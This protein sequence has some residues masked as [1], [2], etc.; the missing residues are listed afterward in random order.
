[1]TTTTEQTI[2]ALRTRL[3]QIQAE[4]EADLRAA[5]IDPN[6]VDAHHPRNEEWT[7][8]NEQL[9]ALEDDTPTP[10]PAERIRPGVALQRVNVYDPHTGQYTG[11]QILYRGTEEQARA[12]A[13]I[14]FWHPEQPRWWDLQEILTTN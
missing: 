2:T 11:R 7:T 5:G 8:L 9:I 6:T 3:N 10:P 13:E 14:G 1:M 4:I 12:H